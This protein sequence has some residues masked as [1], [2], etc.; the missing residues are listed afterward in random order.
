MGTQPAFILPGVWLGA[1]TVL[2]QIVTVQVDMKK[3]KKFA[4]KA[5]RHKDAQRRF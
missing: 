2:V 5:R 1:Q 3:L 4:T